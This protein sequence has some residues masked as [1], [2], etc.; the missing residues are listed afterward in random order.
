MIWSFFVLCSVWTL[1]EL[2]L[3]L[4]PL[5]FFF[6]NITI[7]IGTNFSNF[8]QLNYTLPP[9]IMSSILS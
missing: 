2:L 8:V 1:T 3:A 4:P 6:L 5:H 7:L 9:L